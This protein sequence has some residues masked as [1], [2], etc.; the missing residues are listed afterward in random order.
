MKNLII[1]SFLLLVGLN[2]FGQKINSLTSLEVVRSK[3][4]GSWKHENRFRGKKWVTTFK[5]HNDSTGSWLNNR[6]FN[7]SPNFKIW[8]EDYKYFLQLADIWGHGNDPIEILRLDEKKLILQN[9][10]TNKKYIYLR[11]Q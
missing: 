7:S 4:T 3:L 10:T 9:T 11:N 5:F 2:G 8:E 6:T 1:I